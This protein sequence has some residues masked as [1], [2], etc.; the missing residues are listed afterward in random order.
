MTAHS[1]IYFGAVKTN[2]SIC[3]RLYLVD[4]LTQVKIS[5]TVLK[6]MGVSHSLLGNAQ[7]STYQKNEIHFYY[8]CLSSHGTI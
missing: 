8:S 4:S 1:H 7:F 2:H 6:L 3:V 5:F